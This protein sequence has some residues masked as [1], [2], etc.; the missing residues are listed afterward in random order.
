MSYKKNSDNGN[1]N[2]HLDY[3]LDK[4]RR[5]EKKIMENTCVTGWDGEQRDGKHF[6]S[7]RFLK[8]ISLLTTF[9]LI[10][11][12]LVFLVLWLL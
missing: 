3:I 1:Q 9:S 7:Q 10:L 11:G 6:R 8:I 2:G 12:F 4:H 5:R